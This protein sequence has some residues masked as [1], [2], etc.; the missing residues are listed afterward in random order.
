MSVLARNKDDD[1]PAAH[2]AANQS[3]CANPSAG[4]PP[5]LDQIQ[6][7]AYRIHLDRGGLYGYDLDD[8]LQA[9]RELSEAYRVDAN[10][11]ENGH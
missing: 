5:T 10:T 4:H 3:E 2:G 7:R 1:Q 11:K 8:W 9:E 6:I